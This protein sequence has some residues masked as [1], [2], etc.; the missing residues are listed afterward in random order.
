[1]NAYHGLALPFTVTTRFPDVALAG[2]GTVIAVSL[3]LEGL[4]A[5]PLNVTKL[6]PCVAPNLAP[7]IVITCPTG[8][9]FADNELMTGFVTVKTTPLLLAIPLTVTR[10]VTQLGFALVGTMAVIE[11]LA[12]LLTDARTPPNVTVLLP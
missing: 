10:T 11:L 1:M 7:L 5:T 6:L 8:A 3:Q 12:Q 9:E 4:P 2:T